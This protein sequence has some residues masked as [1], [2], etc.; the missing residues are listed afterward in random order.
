[1]FDSVSFIGSGRIARIMLLMEESRVLPRHVVAFD[2]NPA[3]VA[4]LQADFPSVRAG[5]LDEAAGTDL[6]LRRY[7]P[8]MAEVLAGLSGKLKKDAVLCSLAPKVKLSALKE[9]LGGL[10]VWHA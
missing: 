6:V 9:K 1:M 5:S 4:A 7:I 3:V 10:A 2:N 8:V